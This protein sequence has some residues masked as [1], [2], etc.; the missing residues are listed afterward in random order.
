M[1]ELNAHHWHAVANRQVC[2]FASAPTD[3]SAFVTTVLQ[4]G[5]RRLPTF[6][7]LGVSLV[8]GGLRAAFPVAAPCFKL[9]APDTQVDCSSCQRKAL[10]R[11]VPG[12]NGCQRSSSPCR[13]AL[14][15][16][17]SCSGHPPR[18]QALNVL[19]LVTRCTLSFCWCACESQWALCRVLMYLHRHVFDAMLPC[20]LSNNF[21]WQPR[22]RRVQT[23]RS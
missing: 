20:T 16:S 10:A 23:G 15:N 6:R 13:R 1:P 14:P 11:R 19:P 21:F 5:E 9:R 3:R 12:Q 2:V 4:A 18:K 17:W 8:L 7:S 22:A